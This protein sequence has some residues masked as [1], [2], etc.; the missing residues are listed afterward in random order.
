MKSIT[1]KNLPLGNLGLP[2][3][4]W[5]EYPLFSIQD[6][7]LLMKYCAK[8]GIGVLGVEGFSLEGKYRIPD[9]D[10]IADFSML[11]D[12]AG[13]AFQSQSVDMMRKFIRG[14]PMKEVF[15]EFVL[16]VS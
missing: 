12:M 9:M 16:V 2:T 4:W 14:L 3:R 10:C 13:S 6:G 7:L 8:N 5:G 1:V 11:P 15:L